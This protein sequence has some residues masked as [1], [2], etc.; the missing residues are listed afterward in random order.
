MD[1]DILKV[2]LV[3]DN[4]AL[5][6]K[7]FFEVVEDALKGGVSIVQLREKELS[8]EEFIEKALK[9]K[10]LT[11]KYNV[12]LIINDNINVAIAVDADGL[13]IGQKDI[14][15]YG[16]VPELK[17]KILGITANTPELAI[18]AEK[19]GASYI[20]AG[21]LFATSTK[22]DTKAISYD[23]LSKIT[24]AVNIPVVAIGG[25]TTENAVT[26]KG[27]G[28]AGCALSSGIMGHEDPMKA[29]QIL[30]NIEY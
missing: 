23:T 27:S 14:A 6:G 4:K 26:L 20:G 28:I 29:A 9:L 30:R 5:H 24:S 17:G 19:A 7:D 16:K 13:H 11:K 10:E 25:I 3:T 8:D 22:N 21:A 15:R 12:P 18:E 1:K 2:Y